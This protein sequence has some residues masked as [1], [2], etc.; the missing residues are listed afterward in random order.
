MKYWV[1]ENAAV[2]VVAIAVTVFVLLG[3][4]D[5]VMKSYEVE[6]DAAVA[7]VTTTHE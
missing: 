2:Q 1:F 5:S 4:V 3:F 6:Q 7:S